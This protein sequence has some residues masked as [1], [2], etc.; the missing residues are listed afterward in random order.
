MLWKI[1]VTGKRGGGYPSKWKGRDASFNPGGAE[2]LPYKR[3]G[4]TY[5]SLESK[6][7]GRN[8]SS[9]GRGGGDRAGGCSLKADGR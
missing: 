1:S 4:G 9:C 6:K 8:R 5:F 3:K 2:P 7:D